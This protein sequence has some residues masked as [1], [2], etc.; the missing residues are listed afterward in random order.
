[1]I[2]ADTKVY[3][4]IGNPVSHSLSP[5]LQNTLAKEMNIDMSYS[6]FHV[7]ENIKEAIIGAFALD[8]K[9]FNVTIPYKKDMLDIVSDIDDRAKKIGAI[10]TLIKTENGYKGYNTDI[11]G[12]GM[13]LYNNSLSIRGKDIIILGAG[14]AAKAVLYLAIE[15]G[16][17][18]IT[19]V[20]RN[21]SKAKELKAEVGIKD[22]SVI[23]LDD[24]K[25]NINLLDK[26]NYFV[27]QTT[28]VGMHPNVEDCII[29]EEAFYEKCNSG[30]DLIYT[31]FETSFIKKM[32]SKGKTCINGLDM[33]ILQGVASF[34][35]WNNVKVDKDI[36]EK[37]KVLLTEKLRE[38][39]Q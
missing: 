6:A 1:M 30:I 18:S 12:L 15:E 11:I 21:I 31:P 28:N 5:I 33:L 2:S 10:N 19:L 22:I 23:S 9:G 38:R 35:I 37:V 7:T 3:G 34:E 26:Y 14:G 27:F 13:S 8:I 25:S 32:K 16:V 39:M 24:L 36:I 17:K 4:I 29:E 20:N